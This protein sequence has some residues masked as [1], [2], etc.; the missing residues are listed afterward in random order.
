M[1]HWAR[2]PGLI[3]LDIGR[4]T[5]KAAQLTRRGKRWAS[6]ALAVFARRQAD[7]PV[8]E[9]EAVYI[10]DVLRRR[11]FRGGRVALS[12]PQEALVSSLLELPPAN[13]SVPRER[14]VRMEIA[15]VQRVAPDGLT[16][17]WSELPSSEHAGTSTQALCWGLVH[18]KAAPL[19]D[20]LGRAG[21][22]ATRVE[23]G[24]IALQRGCAQ[25][26]SAA[27]RISA[28]ADLGAGGVRLVLLHQGRVVHER[29]L[30]DCGASALVAALSEKLET[31]PVLAER[32]MHRF[33]VDKEAAG[34][35]LAVETASTINNLV[36]NMIEQVSLSFSFVS[37]QYPSAELGPLLLTGGIAGLP[38]L[39]AAMAEGMELQVVPIT[40]GVVV[41]AVD[42]TSDSLDASLLTAI[43]LAMGQG[44]SHGR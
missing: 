2:Q 12:A 44:V 28:I 30:P 33:G 10:A 11:G 31:P 6:H 19:I 21:L 38:G 1:K 39:A 43:G 29:L 27:D 23:P 42:V 32:A 26:L 34:T 5:V 25:M 35:A 15:R 17:C 18:E 22:E 37:H 3:G 9:N 14:I 7:A 36:D 8:S 13:A 24:S 41:D 40:P 16:C 20:T 4:R